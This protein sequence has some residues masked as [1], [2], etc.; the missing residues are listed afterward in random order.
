MLS[1]PN[2]KELSAEER[3]EAFKDGLYFILPEH[4][5]DT[6]FEFFSQMERP[7]ITKF[8]NENFL[9][10]FLNIIPLCHNFFTEENLSLKK[11]IVVTSLPFLNLNG[12]YLNKDERNHIVFLNEGLL[13][14]IPKI[15]RHL[16]PLLEPSLF[17]G[18]GSIEEKFS[19]VIDIIS[20]L[21]FFKS[22]YLDSRSS[23]DIVYSHADEKWLFDQALT[24]D[25]SENKNKSFKFGKDVFGHNH[26]S[27][28]PLNEEMGRYLACRGAFV[29]L[30][31]HEFSHIYNDHCQHK[32]TDKLNLRDPNY[33][34]ILTRK[35][36]RELN[37]FGGLESNFYNFCVNQPLEEE[38]DAHGLGCVLKYCSDNNLDDEKSACVLIG[39][40]AVFVVMDIH[41]NLSTI[42][43]FGK[44]DAKEYLA[45]N[46]MVRNMVFMGEHP[47]P[48][49]R[50]ELALR[51][52]QFYNNPALEHFSEMNEGL[53]HFCNG[54]SKEIFN[55]AQL[56]ESFLS[57]SAL[58]DSDLSHIFDGYNT[59]GSADFSSLHI[60]RIKTNF[61]K[62]GDNVIQLF[63][64]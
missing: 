17:E 50:L 14:V 53:V 18:R 62:K 58:L 47:T 39:A 33:L 6:S 43:N 19:T 64:K 27:D 52:K 45:L 8:D 42:H 24:D 23:Q 16:L 41:E 35:F 44:N 4:W 51:H 21:F 57:S 5:Y 36:S 26:P 55:N 2:D 9:N 59:L 61:L 13:S 40:I 28:Y 3:Y 46:P 63:R 37:K 12:V 29:F 10:R 20:S 48:I 32:N 54:L 25:I 56:V 30:L 38:A 31:G 60:Q 49:S 22:S 7:G 11:N 15:Y 34:D 1:S